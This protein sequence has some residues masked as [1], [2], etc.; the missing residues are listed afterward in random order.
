MSPCS[1]LTISGLGKRNGDYYV[2]A[3]T[4]RYSGNEGYTTAF[5]V[6]GRR[7][8]TM[9]EYL[10]GGSRQS[11]L[12]RIQGVV[13]GVV[14]QNEDPDKYS[15]VKVKFP[16]LD[17]TLESDWARIASPGAGKDRGMQW[18]PEIDDEVLVTFEHGDIHRPYVLGG[19]WN[20]KDKPP[21]D[22][23]GDL[24]D[25]KKIKIRSLRTREGLDLIMSV[26]L[27]AGGMIF[28]FWPVFIGRFLVDLD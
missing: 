4:H 12:A 10:D 6:G 2:T 13:V 18:V 27:A 15:R 11:G 25:S 8:L 23:S 5:V 3:T 1:K 14:T 26:S 7:S 21:V 28:S 19:L 9:T 22:T 20:G 17:D 24:L 16:W